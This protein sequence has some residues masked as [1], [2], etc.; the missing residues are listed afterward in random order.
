MTSTVLT[1]RSIAAMQADKMLDAGDMDGKAVWMRI[2]RAIDEL[3]A[4]ER[5]E[6]ERIH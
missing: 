5:P 2:I 4:K 3:Q 6:G 1:P